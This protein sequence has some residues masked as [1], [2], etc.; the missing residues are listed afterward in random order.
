MTRYEITVEGTVGHLLASGLGPFEV[1]PATPGRS[2][3]VGDVVDQAALH[4]VLDRLQDLRVEICDV[5]RVDDP[6]G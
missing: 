5:H 1:R 4:G 3:L 6:D 2:C